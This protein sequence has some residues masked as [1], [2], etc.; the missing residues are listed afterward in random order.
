MNDAA[1]FTDI[2]GCRAW[3]AALPLLSPLQVQEMLLEQLFRLNEVALTGEQRFA[4]LESLRDP[5]RF[6]QG[7]AMKRYSGKPLP[8]APL[9]Q[10]ASDRAL[11]LWR[12]LATAYRSCL[13]TDEAALG[14]LD[15][16]DPR[17]PVLASFCQR[18]LAALADEH[19]DSMRAGRRVDQTFWPA[20]H[21][22]YA[23]A[24]RLGLAGVPVADSLRGNPAT[25]AV[26]AYAE[27]MLLAAAGLHELPP[28]QQ[29]WVIQWA[30]RW[31]DRIVIGAAPPAESPS[32]PLCVDLESDGPPDFRPRQGPGARWLDTAALRLTLKKRM[33]L[34][35]RGESP[36]SLGLGEDCTQPA[37]GDTLR[38]V[39]PRWVKGGVARRYARHPLSGPCRFVAGIEAIHYYVAGH[40]PFKPPGSVDMGEL[41]RQ[42]DELAT[43][44]RVATRF[45]DD[46]SHDH[47][48]QMES[49]AVEE[50]WGLFD[51]SEDGLRLV[52]PLGQAGGRLG[53]GQLVA[54]QPAGRSDIRLGVVRWTQV[55]ALQMVAGIQLLPGRSQAVGVRRTGLMARP[56]PYQRGFLLPDTIVLPPG[57]YKADRIVE[58]WTAMV[59]RR[60]RLGE[61]IERGTDFERASC[62][63]VA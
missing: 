18:G 40:Q 11:A 17:A 12:A 9:E 51:Q 32:L 28:R 62:A 31:A 46:Y 29:G 13:A 26:A 60:F 41:R 4:L 30:G 20:A 45:D 24:E 56:D 43:F 37:V 47:A 35:A 25:S 14:P 22:F 58:T 10:A 33:A 61:L 53:I 3:V 6:A 7:E 55:T 1:A 39:Y 57:L 19:S 5:L 23:S 27:V 15:G 16:N 54:V 38:R 63:E 21:G 2:G 8:L 42:R 48:F 59:S 34:L 36:A 49:W 50:D 44:G 52:R